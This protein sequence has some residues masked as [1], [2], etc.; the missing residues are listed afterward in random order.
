MSNKKFYFELKKKF[1]KFMNFFLRVQKINYCLSLKFIIFICL[2]YIYIFLNYNKY[3][4]LT[5]TKKI[6]KSL[7]MH[8]ARA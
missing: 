6:E 1:L 5:F 8:G 2:K 7:S 4:L 3:K